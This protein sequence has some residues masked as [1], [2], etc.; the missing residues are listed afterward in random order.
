MPE[1]SAP[2]PRI[3]RLGLV[4]F[5]AH[6]AEN[7]YPA[8]RLTPGVRIAAIASRDPARAASLAERYDIPLATASW[9][10]LISSG[11]VDA[12]VVSATPRAHCEIAGEALTGGIDIFVEKP[13]APDLPALRD[14][15]GLEARSAAKACVGYNF[16][17]AELIQ[18]ASG[19]VARGKGPRC[20]KIRFV[21]SKPRVPLWECA[22]VEEAFLYGVAIHPIDLAV[23]MFGSPDGIAVSHA[24]LGQG[25]FSMTILLAFSEGRRAILDLGNYS[26]R[27]ECELELLGEDGLCARVSDLR[28]IAVSGHSGPPL[29]SPKEVTTHQLSGLAGGFVASGYAG[30]LEAFFEAIRSGSPSASA[31]SASLPTYE[32]IN[33]CLRSIQ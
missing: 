20:L 21:G 1:V 16:R 8:L 12:L 18:Q 3:L 22:S 5:G 9:R 13:P 14:L 11:D 17:F 15:A 10:E 25:R 33:E 31:L 26:P 24:T 6:M 19:F 2:E 29:L 7:L 23:T 30:A 28:R 27:F 4:G 32:V